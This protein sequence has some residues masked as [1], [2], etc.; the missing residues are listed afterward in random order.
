MWGP[1]G[2]SPMFQ[3]Y[4]CP[5]LGV[6]EV[7]FT[8]GEKSACENAAGN[9]SV[10]D[11][12]R[13]GNQPKGVRARQASAKRRS[14]VPGNMHVSEAG[15]VMR[16]TVCPQNGVRDEV[17]PMGGQRVQFNNESSACKS[18][19]PAVNGGRSQTFSRQA[20]KTSSVRMRR[21]VRMVTEASSETRCP[22]EGV[23]QTAAT[24]QR[25]GVTVHNECRQPRNQ[26]QVRAVGDQVGNA[27][28]AVRSR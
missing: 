18:S 20:A 11:G 12:L 22:K 13:A 8:V 21:G 5:Y 2:G 19:V 16:G 17:H 15:R 6:F 3:P 4:L 27:R 9:C 26:R 1:S 23:T 24:R 25:D 10:Q 7:W 14:E 28:E